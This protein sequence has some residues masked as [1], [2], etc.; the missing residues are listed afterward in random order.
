[1]VTFLF[2]KNPNL[3]HN[4]LKWFFG[5]NKKPSFQ[6]LFSVSCF[7]TFIKMSK[8]QKGKILLEKIVEY[9]QKYFHYAGGRNNCRQKGILHIFTQIIYFVTIYAHKIY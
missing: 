7:W 4:A 8:N 6:R 9:N 2:K 3:E 1:M 5:K